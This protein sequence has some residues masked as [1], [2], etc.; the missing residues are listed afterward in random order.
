MKIGG[1]ALFPYVILREKY[2]DSKTK[3][4]VDANKRTINHES[5]HFQQALELAVIPFYLLYVL[6]WLFKL[7]FYGK[8]SYYQISFEKEAYGNEKDLSYLN[9]RVRY[10]WIYLIF[11]K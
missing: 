2:R 4:W 9:N 8:E 11:G 3:Y 1:M 7:P 10:N 6:E 5:I